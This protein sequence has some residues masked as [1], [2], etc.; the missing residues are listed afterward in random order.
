MEGAIVPYV[1]GLIDKKHGLNVQAAS[2]AQ[3]HAPGNLSDRSGAGLEMLASAQSI[4]EVLDVLWPAGLFRGMEDREAMEKYV[5]QKLLDIHRDSS[6]SH[7]SVACD[8]NHSIRHSAPSLIVHAVRDMA[9]SQGWDE[10]CTLAVV[11]CNMGFAE[12]PKTR[13]GERRH[14]L[15]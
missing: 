5:F 15:L 13:L 9:L 14:K 8:P 7:R 4:D 10:E 11:D 6:T 1:P 12:N 3:V 2:P